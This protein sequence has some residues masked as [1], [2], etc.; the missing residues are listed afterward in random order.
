M[1]VRLDGRVALITRASQG[2]GLAM[3]ITFAEA[4]AK[5]ALVARRPGPLAEA[6]AQIPQGSAVTISAD[7]SEASGAARAYD[8]AKAALGPIDILVNNAGTA[9]AGPFLS[10]SDA[11]WQA[12][13]DLKL[14]AAIRLARLCLPD[15]Q[16]RRWGRVINV[17]NSQARTQAANTSP[18]SVSRAAGLA[19]TKVLAQ[20]FAADNVLVNALL[21]G[22]FKTEQRRVQQ[23]KTATGPDVYAD[24]ARRVP[25]RRVGEPEELANL[26]CF[27][28]SDAASYITGAGINADGGVSH[29]P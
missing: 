17:L 6:L 11:Q 7:V 8:E 28:A 20:E 1:D 5:V 26:A 22:N 29:A 23:A 13:L 25:L 19:L 27:L 14:F 9:A 12:D 21:V 3:A 10:Q 4:G 2:L 24:L 16:A 18:T 15:M